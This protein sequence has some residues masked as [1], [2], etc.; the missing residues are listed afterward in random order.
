MP[1]NMSPEEEAVYTDTGADVLEGMTEDEAAAVFEEP[2]A[3]EHSHEGDD[4]S[5]QS[6]PPPEPPPEPSAGSITPEEFEQRATKV[7]R[8]FGRYEKAVTDQLPMLTDDL[9]R[10]PLCPELHP[11][12]VDVH[13]AGRLPAEIVAVV[14]LFLGHQR[15][16]DYLP[17]PDT[18]AC[19]GCDGLGKVRSGSRVANQELLM[20]PRCNGSGFYP[21]A[22]LRD[23][24]APPPRL[25]GN[26][27]IL[28]TFK[29]ERADTDP[30][31]SPLLLA[32]GTENPNYGRMPQFK[33]ANLP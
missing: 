11:G 7:A 33:D 29:A 1:E 18:H 25:D 21:P 27:N 4:G 31:G 16:A 13:D 5:G 2:P 22:G 8:A 30:W 9:T 12:F 20:C 15:E 19:E 26:G 23:A 6:D 32:N 24:S 10:C 3:G 14:D 28:E 17:S